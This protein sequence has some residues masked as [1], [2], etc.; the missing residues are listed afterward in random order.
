MIL[1]YHFLVPHTVD[2]YC[3]Y[4]VSLW[5]HMHIERLYTL[6]TSSLLCVLLSKPSSLNLIPTCMQESLL[7]RFVLWALHMCHDN[8]FDPLHHPPSNPHPQN[9]SISVSNSW[10]LFSLICCYI[11][12]Y[13]SIEMYI[14]IIFSD[15]IM[16]L[17]HM[18][19]G[20]TIWYWVINYCVHLLHLSIA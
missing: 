17:L 9:S 1:W 7:H 12:L 5:N 3:D 20:L 18:I 6:W 10:S 14:S 8:K 2:L 4:I 16:L 19:P 13:I 15:C 11:F